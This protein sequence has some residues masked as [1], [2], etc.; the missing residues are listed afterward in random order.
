MSS[1]LFYPNQSV[2]LASGPIGGT[3]DDWPSLVATANAFA[4]KSAILLQP[5]T[6]LCKG[7]QSLANGAR[8][9][10][11]PGVRIVSSMSPT[12]GPANCV[13][14]AST[15]ATSGPLA[16]NA[17]NTVGTRTL[18]TTLNTGLGTPS[19]SNPTWIEVGS[20]NRY[21]FY[22]V[23]SISGSGP[24]TLTVDRAVRM[25]FAAGTD[26]VYV[27]APPQ[28]IR[29]E[30]NGMTVSGTGDRAIEL[31]G[32]WN[33]HVS[34][35]TVDTNDGA[36]SDIIASFDIGSFRSTM[37]DLDLSGSSITGGGIAF[38]SAE[39]CFGTRLT[40]RNVTLSG[41]GVGLFF[42]DCQGCVFTACVSEGCRVG[43]TFDSGQASGNCGTQDCVMTDMTITGAIGDGI[44]VQNGSSRNKV[45]RARIG[46]CGS[47]GINVA[48]GIAAC[49]DNT[50]EVCDLSD[51]A[52]GLTVA[53]SQLRVRGID[54]IADRCATNAIAISGDARIDGIR[55]KDSGPIACSG[56]GTL[57]VDGFELTSTL[58]AAWTGIMPTTSGRTRFTRGTATSSGDGG[59][60]VKALFDH[61]GTGPVYIS[62]LRLV[63]FADAGGNAYGYFAHG[64]SQ[65]LRRGPDVDF[66]AAANPYSGAAQYSFGT[67]TLN[68]TT[69]VDITFSDAKSGDLL[70]VWRKTA[71]STTSIAPVWSVTAATKFTV[72]GPVASAND[73]LEYEVA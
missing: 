65:I 18:V 66:S 38:E 36:F 21:A 42:V 68:G 33:C 15:T 31:S 46:Y 70:R 55:A 67:V 8:I 72:T 34:G 54:I 64:S 2:V 37:T 22:K 50:L 26:Q 57:E 63:S 40:A 62:Q 49:N 45:A 61:N 24:Y 25:Q 6:Y 16:L 13:F 51:N 5:G 23:V 44:K 32:A 59:T 69:G 47:S 29:I 20:T 71:G 4:Y 12:G 39:S 11:Q 14:Y 27:K 10:G 28:D 48:G 60:H 17:N 35:I 58:A 19:A 43:A 9:L 73:V 56:A 53:A 41:N 30:G 52:V 7:V 3:S 1:G